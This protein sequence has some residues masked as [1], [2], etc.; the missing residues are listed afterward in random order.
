[1][2]HLFRNDTLKQFD[3]SALNGS[4]VSCKS[5]STMQLRLRPEKNYLEGV[6][7]HHVGTTRGSPVGKG[8][9][10]SK[11]PAGKRLQAYAQMT[12]SSISPKNLPAHK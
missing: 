7:A 1:M 4:P 5:Q 2:N 3:F 8:A 6:R 12:F 10:F 11:G 9:A